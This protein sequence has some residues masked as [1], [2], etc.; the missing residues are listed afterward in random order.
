M[1]LKWH[2]FNQSGILKNI[3]FAPCFHFYTS[4]LQS[5]KLFEVFFWLCSY[6][7]LSKMGMINRIFLCGLILIL[8]ASTCEWLYDKNDLTIAASSLCVNLFVNSLCVSLCDMILTF[9]CDASVKPLLYCVWYAFTLI[10][11]WLVYLSSSKYTILCDTLTMLPCIIQFVLWFF[12]YVSWVSKSPY[13]KL[14]AVY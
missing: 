8:Q 1:W 12:I 10:L 9:W 13:L 4:I 2:K 6:F 11:L 14:H 7:A 3:E 5:R